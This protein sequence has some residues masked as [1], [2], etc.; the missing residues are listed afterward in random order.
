MLDLTPEFFV[1]LGQ[2][3]FTDTDARRV[4]LCTH[5]VDRLSRSRA[6]SKGWTEPSALNHLRAR[7][8]I[9]SGGDAIV[10]T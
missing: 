3:K 6:A 1:T 4:R 9:V 2:H 7:S 8:S 5:K 10:R